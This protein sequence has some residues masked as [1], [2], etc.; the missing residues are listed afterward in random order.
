MEERAESRLCLSGRRLIRLRTGDGRR[1]AAT[2]GL[3]ADSQRN[4]I[5][6]HPPF[7]HHIWRTISAHLLSQQ[8][9]VECLRSREIDGQTGS[10]IVKRHGHRLAHG[11]QPAGHRLQFLERH[12][13]AVDLHHTVG[14]AHILQQSFSVPS[15]QVAGMIDDAGS[16]GTGSETGRREF[17]RIPIAVGQLRPAQPQFAHR[18][19]GQ[20]P[21]MLVDD[22]GRAVGQ[23]TADRDMPRRLAAGEPVAGGIHGELRGAVGIEDRAVQRRHSVEPLAPEAHIGERGMAVAFEQTPHRRGIAPS[24]DAVAVDKLME[25][26][27]VA[28]HLLGHDEDGTSH[29]EHGEEVLHRPVERQ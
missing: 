24:G 14:A 1:Q 21:T 13:I 27:H 3:A 29:G 20:Q 22:I 28:P 23:R 18:T 17:R 2:V 25:T 7:G 26:A 16:E 15:H 11:G 6:L 19:D 4:L 10:A 8:C 12:S 9:G 5:H